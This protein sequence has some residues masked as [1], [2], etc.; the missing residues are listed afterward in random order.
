[1]D[2]DKIRIKELEKQLAEKESTILALQK[3]INEL[4]RQVS[5]LTEVILQMRHDK[6]GR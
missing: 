2:A 3:S 5:N 4:T 1:M 6:Y